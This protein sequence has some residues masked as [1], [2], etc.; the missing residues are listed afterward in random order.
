MA[1]FQWFWI[2]TGEVLRFLL[3]GFRTRA[4]LMAENHFLRKQLSLY[5]ERKIQPRRSDQMTKITMVW[6]SKL[7]RW[8]DALVIVTPTTFLRW[9]RQGFR[10]YWRWK[11][12]GRPAIPKS[13]VALIQTM[14]ND[15]PGWSPE[16]IANELSLKLSIEVSPET[17][18]KYLPNDPNRRHRKGVSSQRWRTFL[19]NHLHQTLACD[20]FITVSLNFKILY[21]LVIMDL[22][23]RRIL[24]THVTQHPTAA[25]TQ[26]QMREAVPSDHEYRFILHDRDSI[27]SAD[28]DRTLNS[29]RLHVLKTPPRTPQANGYCERL[30]GTIRREL[31]DHFLIISEKHLIRCLK[32]WVTHYNH[33]RPHV[34]L[35]PGIPEPLPRKEPPPPTHHRHLLPLVY[36][37]VKRPVLGGLHHEYGLKK[38]A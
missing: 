29:L 26:Q 2:L 16:R 34:S 8:Q 15:N 21:V 35:G 37:V 3:R 5:Q 12:R 30:I 17:V 1:A 31:T 10:Y 33:A 36:T 6:L 9:H 19:Q 22:G 13:L 24:R 28:V 4:R 27:F 20:F 18:R 14:A 32:E 7:F 11:C 38:A 23:T 25:W